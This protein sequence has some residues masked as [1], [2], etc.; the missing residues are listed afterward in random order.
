[1]RVLRG[2]SDATVTGVAM[3]LVS[4]QEEHREIMPPWEVP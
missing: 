2:Y 3:H 1:M 4:V